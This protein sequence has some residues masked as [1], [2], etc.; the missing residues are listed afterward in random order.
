[1]QNSSTFP[2]QVNTVTAQTN[3]QTITAAAAEVHNEQVYSVVMLLVCGLLTLFAT[4]AAT[5]IPAYLATADYMRLIAVIVFFGLSTAG[6]VGHLVT[7]I[8]LQIS[9]KSM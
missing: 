6:L 3:A 5:Q 1:M 9:K 4:A 7:I 2:Q 8:R